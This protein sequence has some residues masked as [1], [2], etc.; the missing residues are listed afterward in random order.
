MHCLRCIAVGLVCLIA[1]CVHQRAV[2]IRPDAPPP[3]TRPTDAA[4]LTLDQ[5]DPVPVLPRPATMPADHQ[6]SL[7]SI[8]F[9]AQAR[10]KQLA[11]DR[12]GAVALLE[13]AIKLDPDSFEVNYTLGQV[14]LGSEGGVDAGL[15]ALERAAAIQPDNLDVQL[16]L[17][18]Q[19]LARD[20]H[21]QAILHLRLALLTSEYKARPESGLLAHLLLAR[22]LQQKGYDTAALSQYEVL[23]SRMQRRL[24]FRGSPELY[25][26][27]SRPEMIYVQMGQLHEK[28]GRFAEA[29]EKY[30]QAVRREPNHLEFQAH[31]VRVLLELKRTGAARDLAAALVS[32]HRAN[33][34]SVELLREVYKGGEEQKVIDVLREILRNRPGDRAI[35]FALADV[36]DSFG[37]SEEAEKLLREALGGSGSDPIVVSRLYEFYV[38]RGQTSQ[39]AQL[40][41]ST[42]GRHPEQLD[43]LQ[44]LWSKLLR[45]TTRNRLRLPMVQKLEVA[46]ESAAAKL[47][48]MSQLADLWGRETLARSYLEQA[49]ALQ[50]PFAPAYREQLGAGLG[51]EDRTDEHKDR[52]A[53]QLIDQAREQKRPELAAELQGLFLLH[54]KKNKEAAAALE[55]A[56]RLGA[57]TPAVEFALATAQVGDGQDE[58]AEQTLWK[59]LRVWPS[60]DEAYIV[61]FR[62]YLSKNA[63]AQALKVLQSWLA[64]DPFNVNARLL[65]VTVLTQS[66][67]L[68]GAETT[69]SNLFREEPD[70]PAVVAEMGRFYIRTKKVED[71]VRK[72]EDER[73][74][75]PDNRV[76]VDALLSVY[77]QQKKSADAL[78]VLD[79]MRMAV[80]GDP[81][82]L[83]FVAHL[84][85][86]VQRHEMTEKVLQEVLRLDPQNGPAN[87]DLGYMWADEGKNMNQAEAMIRLAVQAESDNAA[88][89]DSL[90]W[91]L[92]K[93]GKFEEAR[94]WLDEAVQAV[95]RPDPVVLDHLGDVLYR[96]RQPQEAAQVWQRSLDRLS[97]ANADREE[98]RK[99]QL[100]LRQKLRQHERGEPVDVAPTVQVKDGAVQARN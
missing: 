92:Y 20:D 86:R 32:E 3:A 41:I 29:L 4:L 24:S 33:P 70:N 47:Y 78:R 16:Q 97:Q 74:K 83:Y 19:Y 6:S 80:A 67:H 42:L 15:R 53:R 56:I 76:V 100:Q 94:R 91:V 31:V 21:A 45:P 87:N 54:R 84:Y 22:A 5:I 69:L 26:V 73:V 60:Y 81:E 85:E 55:E 14:Q 98:Y 27:L 43:Q 71:L 9:F 30:R 99:L 75:H 59:I 89:M 38:A 58:Q 48:L 96:L 57:R 49:V 36:L 72:L 1:G 35:T 61:L 63:G 44:P 37:K 62:R 25:L 52:L 50:P 28:H 88:Y 65:Q 95:S 51:R 64:A 12:A 66:D 11:G 77:D 8:Q 40:V 34:R 13:K 68:D 17:G 10:A 39:A 82:Q 2:T 18:R 46:P 93:R 7:E 79:Q 23:V 90:G